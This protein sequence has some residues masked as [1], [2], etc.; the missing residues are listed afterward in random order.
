VA[1]LHLTVTSRADIRALIFRQALALVGLGLLI[2]LAGAGL[3]TRLV[4]SLLF[5]VSPLDEVTYAGVL[6][7]LLIVSGCAT[8][9]PASRAARI[10][11]AVTLRT[12]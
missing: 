8:L 3:S 4:D 2:G 5:G 6:L 11:P 10:D 9:V 1:G 7:L 12:D